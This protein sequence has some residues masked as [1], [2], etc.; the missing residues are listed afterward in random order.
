[1]MLNDGG[2]CRIPVERPGLGKVI[3]IISHAAREGIRLNQLLLLEPT[4]KKNAACRSK[5]RPTY[6][7]GRPYGRRGSQAGMQRILEGKTI[8]DYNWMRSTPL[9]GAFHPRHR[10]CMIVSGGLAGA[11]RNG[12]RRQACISRETWRPG[13]FVPMLYVD[14]S[15]VY[16]ARWSPGKATTVS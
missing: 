3:S 16:D 6:D 10:C 5:I 11:Q 12:H 7:V 8:L 1:M 4:E 15:E 2:L 13:W 9:G 14:V